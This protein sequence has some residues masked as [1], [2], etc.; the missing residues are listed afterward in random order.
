MALH[1]YSSKLFNLFCVGQINFYSN[2]AATPSTA[3][4]LAGT[5]EFCHAMSSLV[6]FSICTELSFRQSYSSPLDSPIPC[7]NRCFLDITTVLILGSKKF[8]KNLINSV[9]LKTTS[10][11][12]NPPHLICS[13][14]IFTD[15]HCCNFQTHGLQYIKSEKR[16]DLNGTVLK[17]GNEKLCPICNAPSLSFSHMGSTYL[18][19]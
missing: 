7:H 19:M 17:V 5:D 2:S 9:N 14:L 8:S 12:Q 16:R 1:V 6:F 10:H 13:Y 11:F 3:Y 18:Y 4:I 15:T